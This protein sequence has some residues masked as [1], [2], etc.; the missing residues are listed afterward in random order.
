M[1]LKRLPVLTIL[2]I[3]AVLLT[4]CAPT[5]HTPR[6]VSMA[7]MD[8]MP[9]KVLAAAPRVQQAYQ[10]AVANPDVAAHLPCYCG[11]GGLGHMNLKDCYIDSMDEAGNVSYDLHAV[12]CNICVDI[13]HDAIRMYGEGYSPGE[14][15]DYVDR[16]YSELG[17]S[18]MW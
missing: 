3:G 10:F 12:D 18:N 7:G 16:E 1:L 5:V 6:E 8:H 13:T 9:A 11:C 15:K 14:I 2:L 17:P 4:A